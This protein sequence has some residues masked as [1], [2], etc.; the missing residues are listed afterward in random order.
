FAL[1]LHQN[2]GQL[3]PDDEHID[4]ALTT[5][6]VFTKE[7]HQLQLLTLYEQRLNRNLQK[8][9]ALLQSL[10]ATRKAQREAE[11]KEACSLLQLSEM[12]GLEYQPAKDGFVFS[13]SEIHARIDR[14]QRLHRASTM[15]FTKFRPRNFQT[16]A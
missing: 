5:A 9:M 1:G 2:A 6:R 3:C 16:R 8:N 10:Q 4:A 13:N 15:D 14:Q 11:M 7:S 12:R